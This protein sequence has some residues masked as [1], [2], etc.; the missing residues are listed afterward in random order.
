MDYFSKIK[1]TRE[2]YLKLRYYTE[3]CDTEIS[4][5][6]KVRETPDGFEIYSIEIL[7]QNVSFAHSSLDAESLAKFLYEK[8]RN[9]EKIK[10]YKVWWHSHVN[11]DS[12]FSPIDDRTINGSTEFPYLISIVTNK[13]KKDLIRLDLHKP[14]RLTIPIEKLEIILE[15]DEY[16]KNQCLKEIEEKVKTRS[17]MSILRGK[18]RKNVYLSHRKN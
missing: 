4:G 5:L 16:L 3:C 7:D 8:L 10:D 9:N 15:E 11:M 2:A 18:K 6:G 17:P 13:M 12:Y 1:I 14:F